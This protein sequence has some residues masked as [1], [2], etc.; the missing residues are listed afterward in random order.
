MKFH[1]TYRLTHPNYLPATRAT[2]IRAETHTSLQYT[3][4]SLKAK[5][6]A[7]GY[8]VRILRVV[9]DASAERWRKK[10]SFKHH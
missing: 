2:L 8:H 1:V 10:I 6:E 9:A 7:R 4:V 3:L 5:W